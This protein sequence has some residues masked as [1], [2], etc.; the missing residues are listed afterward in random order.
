M[1]TSRF[2]HNLLMW[3]IHLHTLSCT[4]SWYN[5]SIGAT[6]YYDASIESW[7]MDEMI[8]SVPYVE[9]SIDIQVYSLPKVSV[10]MRAMH[11]LCT[12]HVHCPIRG[13]VTAE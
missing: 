12:W 11:A 6:M 1:C 5:A 7:R 10:I 8:P 9:G 3:A 13:R 2:P 4:Q